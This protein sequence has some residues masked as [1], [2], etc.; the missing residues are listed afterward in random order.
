MASMRGPLRRVRARLSSVDLGFAVLRVVVAL[1]GLGWLLL[2]P[3]SPDVR[4]AFSWLFVGFCVY[5]VALYAALFRR[6]DQ[7][8]RIYLVALVLDASALCGVVRHTGGVHSDFL[9]GFYL[10]VALHGF[11]YGWRM[12]LAVAAGAAV[13]SLVSDPA[14]LSEQHWTSTVARLAFLP[15]VAIWVGALSE[16]QRRQRERAEQLNRE[17]RQAWD[18]AQQVQDKLR[19]ADRLAA[20]GKVAAQLAHQI[21]NPLGSIALNVEMLQGEIAGLSS[22][23]TAEAQDLLRSVQTEIDVLTELTDNYLRFARLPLLYPRP[24]D[25]NEI[26]TELVEFLNAEM[27]RGSVTI[28]ADLAAEL[29]LVRLDRTQ[30]KLAFANLMRNSLEAME[31]GGRLHVATAPINGAV[32]IELSDTGGG[33]PRGDEERIFELFYSTKTQGSGL[34]LTMTRKIVEDHGGTI[35]CSSVPGAGTTFTLEVPVDGRQKLDEPAHSEA[36][37]YAI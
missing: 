17:L 24:T 30:M 14:A 33:I 8:R 19:Q 25:V 29:P 21:K 23:D 13:L 15:L 34:G 16:H 11:Y 7:A 5:S 4:R 9:L 36:N 10:M 3:V 12:G 26:L 27:S 18:H 20:S 1:G 2:A 6:P 37:N 32:R 35:A 31:G 28:T 22:R